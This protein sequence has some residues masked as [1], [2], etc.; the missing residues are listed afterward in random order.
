[1][2]KN[3]TTVVILAALLISGSY[4]NAQAP[5]TF[6]VA[7]FDLD[8][9]MRALPE[10]RAV[11]S[12]VQIYQR[13]TLGA[14][15]DLYMSEY[16]RLDSTFKADSALK[17]SATVLEYT[18]NQRQQIG[19]NLVYWQQI[20]QNK[21]NQYQAQLSQPLYQRVVT[22][23]KKIIAARKYNLVL[24]PGSYEVGTPIENLFPLVAKEMKVTL[25]PELMVDPNKD[26]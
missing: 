18:K 25:P 22:A 9:M 24:K 11:D 8:I 20:S 15:Y 2:K 16:Q 6:K 7:V 10:Y 21:S 12:M 26:L 13:D 14:E 17:K 3:L 5:A 1:M 19:Y 4:S 23:Y